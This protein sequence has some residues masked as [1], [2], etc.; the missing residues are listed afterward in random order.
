MRMYVA[1]QWVETEKKIEV[2]N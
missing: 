1:G 2:L